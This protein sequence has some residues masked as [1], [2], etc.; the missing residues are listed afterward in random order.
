[1][2]NNQESEMLEEKYIKKSFNDTEEAIYTTLGNENSQNGKTISCSSV[3]ENWAS[4]EL[5]A[6]NLNINPATAKV[7]LIVGSCDEET[8]EGNQ[9]NNIIRARGG[10]DLVY[11]NNGNDR[12]IGGKGSDHLIGDSIST[13]KDFNNKGQLLKEDFRN[14]ILKGGL[15][16]DIVVDQYGSDKLKG[17]K[18]NDTL[19]SISDSGIPYENKKI[20][21]Q[22]DD[23]N[24][25]DKLKFRRRFFNP[26][27][28]ES[29]DRLTGGE[30]SD[31]FQWNLLIN[32]S[33]SI[34]DNNTTDGG[35]INWGMNG[36]AGENENYHDHWVDGIG[37]DVITDF[38]GVGG[39]KD[40][41]II[42]GHTVK[43]E[44]LFEK[45]LK[46]VIGLYSDQGNDGERGGGAHDFDVLGKIVVNH[47]G[48]FNFNEDISVIGVDYG[49]YGEGSNV[50]EAFGFA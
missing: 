18:G 42:K 48:N 13:H 15:G 33:K 25:L 44:L 36:V 12:L 10:D 29:N 4:R 26:E 39:E 20:K 45:D 22:N 21:P 35:I 30:G 49:A 46:A 23:G 34:V 14:D 16:D 17:G 28:F 11:G 8:I 2:K 37:R 9:H 31:T 19:I 38:S 27:A 32:A 40:K 43:A 47:D 1:M 24:D 41:I 3:K 7:S 5:T 6:E 50:H